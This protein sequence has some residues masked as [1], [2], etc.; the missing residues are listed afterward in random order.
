MSN[1]S[2]KSSNLEIHLLSSNRERGWA[3][4]SDL[5]ELARKVLR[6]GGA[7][8]NHVINQRIHELE[9]IQAS[10]K[11]FKKELQKGKVEVSL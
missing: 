2:V 1:K 3:H 5:P 9:R 11:N 6:N 8:K 7:L 10:K 4:L